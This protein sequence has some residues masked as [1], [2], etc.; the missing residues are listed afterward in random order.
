MT[1]R[2]KDISLKIQ[3]DCVSALH[4][5]TASP[6]VTP[7]DM[8]VIATTSFFSA[9]T[10]ILKVSELDKNNEKQILNTLLKSHF[11]YELK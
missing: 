9:F 10:A 2:F 8:Q 11:G 5:H 4:K 6:D 1:H 3:H 7:R